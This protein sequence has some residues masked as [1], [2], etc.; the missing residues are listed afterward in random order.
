MLCWSRP[1]SNAI[2]VFL[3]AQRKQEFSY[4]SV[5]DTRDQPPKGFAVEHN[6]VKLGHEAETFERAKAAIRAWKMF[7]TPWVNLCWSGAAIEP[8]TTVAILMRI[9]ILVGER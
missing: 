7:E 8:G 6:Q 4:S 3:N 5:G 9:R 1:S 2:E